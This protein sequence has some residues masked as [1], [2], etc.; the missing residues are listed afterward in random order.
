[1]PGSEGS[2]GWGLVLG[3]SGLNRMSSGFWPASPTVARAS[4]GGL[5]INKLYGSFLVA[6]WYKTQLDVMYVMDTTQS[7]NTIG[8]ARKS[9]GTP[10]ND[11]DVG[12]EIDWLNTFTVYKNLT[13]QVGLG[14]LFAGDAMDYAIIGSA[15]GEN[16]G[17]KNP[18]IF[19]TN[20]TYTF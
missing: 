19:T 16:R 18:Y 3:G 1:M 14:Y 9:D 6:P 8:N 13:W 10:R 20:L 7:G 11:N 12:F 2:P 4:F 5:W 17:P 15:N